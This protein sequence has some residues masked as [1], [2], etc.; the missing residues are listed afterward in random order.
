MTIFT[1][2]T[3][4]DTVIRATHYPS[5]T[6]VNCPKS[7]PRGSLDCLFDRGTRVSLLVKSK[8]VSA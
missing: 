7:G 6:G 4:G 3:F 8:R 2:V 5:D 1:T